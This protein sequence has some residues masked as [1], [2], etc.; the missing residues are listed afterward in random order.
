MVQDLKKIAFLIALKR[1][2]RNSIILKGPVYK[3]SYKYGLAPQTFK[4]YL[5]EAIELGLIED[6]GDRYRVIGFKA[7]VSD[8]CN[9]H[10]VIL[11]KH[12]LLRSEIT[13]T[14]QIVRELSRVLVYDNVVF[15]QKRAIENKK[16]D[17]ELISELVSGTGK[18]KFYSKSEIKKIKAL[19][20]KKQISVRHLNRLKNSLSEEIITSCRSLSEKFG[21]SPK[22]A[23]KILADGGE[24]F[25]REIKVDWIEDA[26]FFNFE[27]A[28]ELNPRAVVHPLPSKNK[29]KVNHGSRLS[30]PFSAINPP[31]N[32][33]NSTE[34]PEKNF[35]LKNSRACTPPHTGTYVCACTCIP[36]CAHA[37]VHTCVSNSSNSSIVLSM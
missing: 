12:L 17:I 21:V 1:G 29:I 11:R 20:K 28:R 36:A 2:R 22:K 31:Q 34:E 37:C 30:K 8:F 23:N 24:I 13:C 6:L 35:P 26:T 16:K 9:E 32:H 27:M 7:I 14:K 3:I 4:K 15:L 33:F 25:K 5:R 19:Q 18:N 10:K